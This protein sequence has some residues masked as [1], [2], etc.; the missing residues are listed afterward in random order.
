MKKNINWNK[1]TYPVLLMLLLAECSLFLS[2]CSLPFGRN[3]SED[4]FNEVVSNRSGKNE[5]SQGDNNKGEDN[6]APGPD[7]D[8]SS[9]KEASNASFAQS[10][11]ESAYFMA[12][13]RIR[14]FGRYEIDGDETNGTEDI[15]WLEIAS[16]SGKTLLLSRYG[17]DTIMNSDNPEYHP[18]W[19]NSILR[20]WMNSDFY[21]AA[22]SDSEKS[23]I[24]LSDLNTPANSLSGMG[25]CHTQD[26][27]FALSYEELKQYIP[28]VPSDGYTDYYISN[29]YYICETAPAKAYKACSTKASYRYYEQ[30]AS[31]LGASDI[32]I[33]RPLCNWWLRT[34]SFE[35]YL[36]VP[37]M[38][39]GYTALEN[40]SSWMENT[41]FARPAIWVVD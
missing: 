34:S 33:D 11:D 30:Y 21:N 18:T 14:N 10:D 2:G 31:A 15:E 5:T 1:C 7:N 19:E 22:F 24:C 27:V 41:V 23:K 25:E 38:R 36:G 28:P 29:G 32:I 4:T 35:G 39:Y 3:K 8:G 17:I 37:V 16:E 26:Y 12:D 9:G 6:N 13:A 20:E 40:N